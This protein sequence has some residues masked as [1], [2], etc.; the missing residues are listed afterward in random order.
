VT[1]VAHHGL[2]S[3]LGQSNETRVS[4]TKVGGEG[5]TEEI[6]DSKLKYKV[7]KARRGLSGKETGWL[8]LVVFVQARS[9]NVEELG[10]EGRDSKQGSVV[11][12]KWLQEV[13]PIGQKVQGREPSLTMLYV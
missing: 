8:G 10:E 7:G 3:L 2:N 1:D 13:G 12:E 4:S 6:G 5:L 9:V 11:C